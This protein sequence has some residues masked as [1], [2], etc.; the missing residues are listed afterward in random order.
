MHTHFTDR[1]IAGRCRAA[2]VVL[3]CGLY[4]LAWAQQGPDTKTN[5]TPPWV[6][7]SD[8]APLQGYQR[9]VDSTIHS[10]REVNDQVRQIGGWRTYAREAAQPDANNPVTPA[11]AAAT[12]GAH[13][14][15]GGHQ[16]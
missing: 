11:S 9:Y 1:L 6:V 4:P 13:T 16:P 15:H 8:V 10:W 5:A 7:L 12:S 2:C 3:L 14:G